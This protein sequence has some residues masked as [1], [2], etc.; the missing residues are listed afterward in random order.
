MFYYPNRPTL[1]PPDP[2]NP[3]NP[4]P[5]YINSLEQTGSYLAEKKFNGD[6]CYYFSSERNFWNRH[7]LKH[8]YLPPEEV[9]EELNNLPK[10]AH[11]N[12]EL[13]NYKTKT[14]KHLLVVHCIMVW[15]DKPLLGS[16]WQSS[17]K[18]LEDTIPSTNKHVILSPVYYSNFWNLFNQADGIDIE[19]IVLK[20]P[21]GI[22]VHS[23]MPIPDCSWML[24]IRKPCKK[25]QF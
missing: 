7:K 18:I 15:K 24:K 10:K 25:Y 11:Y 22:L 2:V 9:L 14:T 23:T 5:D 8:R 19:G 16:Q 13:C 4:A 21:K 17:R 3:T 6:N 1:V 12:L 20:N